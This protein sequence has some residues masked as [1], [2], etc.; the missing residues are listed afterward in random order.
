[1]HTPHQAPGKVGNGNSTLPVEL[2]LT[3]N[4]KI[5]DDISSP[6]FGEMRELIAAAGFAGEFTLLVQ[7]KTKGTPHTKGLRVCSPGRYGVEITW[8]A[9][10]N[11]NRILMSL[12]VPHGMDSFG[13]H[14]RLKQA[15]TR[16]MFT[17]PSFKGELLSWADECCAI[18]AAFD[19][20]RH[21]ASF[22]SC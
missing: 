18:A 14:N 20:G 12:S 8:H 3:G 13:F 17:P 9:G 10:S 1:M 22:V 2:K 6:F 11:D 7:S 15:E 21:C 5:R 16:L 19:S 4:Q